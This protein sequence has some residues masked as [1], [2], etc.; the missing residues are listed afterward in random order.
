MV[1]GYLLNYLN[2]KGVQNVQCFIVTDE[3][4]IITSQYNGKKIVPIA[5]ANI[6]ND[7]LVLLAMKNPARKQAIKKCRE[8]HIKDFFEISIFGIIVVKYILSKNQIVSCDDEL[9]TIFL[10]G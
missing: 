7:D 1:G 5:K 8:E 10:I 9:M 2:H 4:Q 3:Q 6:R